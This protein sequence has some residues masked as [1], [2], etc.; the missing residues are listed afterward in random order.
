VTYLDVKS[1]LIVSM[2][3]LARD[4]CLK[5][6]DCLSKNDAKKNGVKTT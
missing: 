2:G 5:F 4:F 3:F 6:K 1:P